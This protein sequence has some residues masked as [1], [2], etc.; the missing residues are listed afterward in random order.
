MRFRIAVAGLIAVLAWPVLCASELAAEQRQ[1]PSSRVALD[2][3]ATYTTAKLFS[4]FVNE[5]LGVSL[6]VV[7]LPGAAYQQLATGLTPEALA[8]KGV[9]HAQ[10]GKLE[11]PEPYLYMQAEQDSSQ[12][13][14]AKFLMA[15]NEQDITAL[16]TANVQKAAL[17]RGAIKVG[18]VEQILASARIAARPAPARDVFRL[19]YLGPFKAAGSL[20]GTTQIYTLDGRMEPPAKSATRASLIVAPSLDRRV[21]IEADTYAETLLGGL[22]GIDDVKVVERRRI[23]VDGKPAVE[24]V[25]TATDKQNGGGKV[26]LYQVL[27]LPLAG[28]YVRLVGQS[29]PADAEALLPELRRITTGFR[30]LE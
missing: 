13:P 28:G 20:L 23:E 27:I 2:L 22:A 25:A 6:V 17:D 30:S 10:A 15:F 14:V 24:I 9:H 18:D 8:T 4:G 16:I 19:T 26:H 7:E 1:A 3:P 5:D 21:V 12:G 11:R 29:P